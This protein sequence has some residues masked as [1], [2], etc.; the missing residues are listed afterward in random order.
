[1]DVT[2]AARREGDRT[3]VEVGGE[4]D[5][6]TAPRLRNALHDAVSDG[7]RHMVV[8][9]TGT[10]FLDSSALGVLVGVLKHLR[11]RG[12]DLELVCRSESILRV[13]RITGLLTI[14]VVH[15]HLGDAL[16]TPPI[17]RP[18]STDEQTWRGTPTAD[19]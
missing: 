18:R 9:L 10:R 5:V 19:L 7:A 3:V 17:A 14:F 11:V 6:Y 12:G 8:D 4:L 16:S 13:F 15:A 2:V 1:M